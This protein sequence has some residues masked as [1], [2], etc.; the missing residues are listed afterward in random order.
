MQRRGQGFQAACGFGLPLPGGGFGVGRGGC[1]AAVCTTGD[2]DIDGVGKLTPVFPGV[3]GVQAVGA[4]Q[5]PQIG[6]G[7]VLAED[8]GGVAAVGGAAADDV[9]VAD[10][11]ARVGLRRQLRHRQPVAGVG[12][13]AAFVVGVAGGQED[14]GVERQLVGKGAGDVQMAVVDGVEAAAEQADGGAAGRG[15]HARAFLNRVS[16]SLKRHGF[17]VF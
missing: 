14:D 10:G 4:E 17:T 3:Q 2:S 7:E 8:G 11:K 1:G 6:G 13:A 16:G 9:A 5:P 12:A 15:S